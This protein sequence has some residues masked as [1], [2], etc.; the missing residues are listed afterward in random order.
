MY[1]TP[2]TTGAGQNLE[3]VHAVDVSLDA[4]GLMDMGARHTF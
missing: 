3:R 2:L 4:N 1:N